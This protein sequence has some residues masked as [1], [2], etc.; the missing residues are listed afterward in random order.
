MSIDELVFNHEIEVDLFW[1]EKDAVMH[2][3]DRVTRYSV[4]RFET[5][6]SAENIWNMIIDSWVTIFTGFPNII[7]HD[8]GRQFSL[9][10]FKGACAEFGII[11]KEVPTESHNS[12]GLCERYHPNIRRVFRMIKDEYPGMDRNLILSL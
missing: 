8:R 5:S 10:F 2:I 1:I 3:I 11:A 12:I 6:Q 7:S 4:A 9:E